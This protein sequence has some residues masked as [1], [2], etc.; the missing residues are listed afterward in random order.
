MRTA[1]ISEWRVFSELRRSSDSSTRPGLEDGRSGEFYER[2][3]YLLYLLPAT[4]RIRPLPAGR[5][6]SEGASGKK[7]RSRTGARFRF[8]G[9]I[10]AATGGTECR[11]RR[12]RARFERSRRSRCDRDADR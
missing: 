5:S 12:H 7:H 10:L 6:A 1:G 8:V 11:V 3:K 4:T 2:K 9:A